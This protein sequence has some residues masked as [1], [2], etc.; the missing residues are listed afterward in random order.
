[1]PAKSIQ[2]AVKPGDVRK[3]FNHDDVDGRKRKRNAWN[4]G[5]DKND[6]SALI[7]LP[8]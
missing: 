5:H 6:Y 7:D 8:I 2:P 4:Q 3:E 1:M